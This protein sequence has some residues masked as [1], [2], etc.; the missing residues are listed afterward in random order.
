MTTRMPIIDGFFDFA[1]AT[2]L[3]DG[4]LAEMLPYFS[5]EFYNPSALY[6]A[7]NPAIEA[8]L[9]ARKTVAKVIGCKQSEVIFTSGC[10]EANNLA[11]SGV[12]SK[13]IGGKVLV[14][15]IE[16]ESVA[17]V[18]KNYVH[19]IVPVTKLGII[20]LASLEK[21][22]DDDV[23]LISVM[24]VNNELGTVQPLGKISE[25]VARVRKA[26]GSKGKPLYLHTD[27]A[28]A[29]NTMPILRSS[30]GV[31]LMSLNGGKIYGPKGSGCLMA[32]SS[33]GI[34]PIIY[35]GGQESGLRSGTE[36]VPA[37][38][39][40]A[41]AL[42]VAVQERETESAR[43]MA[44]R[45]GL[46]QGLK[47]IGGVI[48]AEAGPRAST[49]TSVLFPS[50]D[51]ESLLYLLSKQGYS[52]SSGSACH[53]RSGE[54]SYVLSAI[55]ISEEGGMSTI[56]ISLGR[57]TSEQGIVQLVETITRILA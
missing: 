19:E 50:T 54:K 37:I 26:R 24:Y 36:N 39:G 41:S 35:G 21:Q 48:H 15:A 49:I 20:D 40:F 46:E 56:R 18:V 28:Q 42:S 27:A 51:N 22:I 17:A 3:D 57:P 4:V 25:I 7:S 12:M 33:V 31:D 5:Q 29:P 32:I 53:A 16:H 6:Q 2:P 34:G 9:R 14:S 1:S 30:L 13:N 11:I 23:V 44:L 52:V 8:V 38:I 45:N 10:T 55:G 43:L 47:N